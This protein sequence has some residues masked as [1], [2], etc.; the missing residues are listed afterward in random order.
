MIVY[1]IEIEVKEIDKMLYKKIILLRYRYIAYYNSL[2]QEKLLVMCHNDTTNGKSKYETL[3]NATLK[4]KA[5]DK[6]TD[7][8][9]TLEKVLIIKK[10]NDS[11]LFLAVQQGSRKFENDLVVVINLKM[12]NKA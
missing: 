12:K 5:I 2:S 3:Y 4:D 11:N 10:I 1:A 7:S 8:Y 6:V 9:V